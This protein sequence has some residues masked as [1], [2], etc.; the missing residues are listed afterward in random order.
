MGK[1]D[2]REWTSTLLPSLVLCPFALF[3]LQ[4]LSVIPRD[5]VLLTINSLSRYL[6]H[7]T[8]LA[9]GSHSPFF[10]NLGEIG[11]GVHLV[12]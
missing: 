3:V 2:P 12:T 6:R 4:C 10:A 7:L 9:V 1:K 5:N 8:R 11:I